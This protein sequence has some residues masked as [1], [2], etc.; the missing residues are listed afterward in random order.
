MKS[1][2]TNGIMCNTLVN[3][4]TLNANELN[5]RIHEL[6]AFLSIY[7]IDITLVLKTNFSDEKFEKGLLGSTH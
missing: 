6:E 1:K 5:Q 4:I 2:E 7:N 3:K